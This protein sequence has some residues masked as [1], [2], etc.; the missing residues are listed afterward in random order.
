LTFLREHRGYDENLPSVFKKMTNEEFT[1][2]MVAKI[3]LS[4][5]G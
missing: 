5:N 4:N 3:F 2:A 1:D